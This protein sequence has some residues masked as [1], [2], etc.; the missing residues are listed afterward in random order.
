MTNRILRKRIGSVLLI[1]ICGFLFPFGK[2]GFPP[3][4]IG[5]KKLGTFAKP[6]N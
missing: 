4:I 6:L 1:H 5:R 3:V 2:L